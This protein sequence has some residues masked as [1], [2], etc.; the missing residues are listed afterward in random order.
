[1][2]ISI[3][4]QKAGAHL[5]R[6]IVLR[7]IKLASSHCFYSGRCGELNIILINEKN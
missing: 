5:L 6:L 2:L 1:M 7:T 3:S 4:N